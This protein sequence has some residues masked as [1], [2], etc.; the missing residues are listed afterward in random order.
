MKTRYLPSSTQST[1]L[2]DFVWYSLLKQI[3]SV[4]CK[5]VISAQVCWESDIY[6][7]VYISILNTEK[8]MYFK[9]LILF[10]LENIKQPMVIFCNGASPHPDLKCLFL[11]YLW[12]TSHS[13]QDILIL[14]HLLWRFE[15]STTELT[16]SCYILELLWWS[17]W[18]C[19]NI[20]HPWH[21]WW[22][23]P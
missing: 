13:L 6:M 20:N 5:S 17:S 10:V 12:S 11:C 19:N 9:W 22:I 7:Y 16:F 21:P 23:K 15:I 2:L 18:Y 14:I 1:I 8:P 4:G 3:D